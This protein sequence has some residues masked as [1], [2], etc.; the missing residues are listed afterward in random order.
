M[1]A[2]EAPPPPPSTGGG[3]KKKGEESGGV[4]AMMD[5]MKADVEKETQELEF[6]E[7]DA[8]EEYEEM[9]K[10]ASEK[11]AAMTKS[12]AE[13]SGVKATMEGELEQTKNDLMAHKKELSN[14]KEYLASVHDDCDWLLENYGTR[15]E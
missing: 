12:V 3:Y 9:T 15:K 1:N 14:T 7:K 11:R 2:K 6:Q 8:Q 10:D 5:A 13:K 4:I